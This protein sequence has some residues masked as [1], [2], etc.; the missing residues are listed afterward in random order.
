MILRDR[1]RRRRGTRA[2]RPRLTAR[3]PPVPGPDAVNPAARPDP[4]R[5]TRPAPAAGAGSIH[6][7]HCAPLWC[8]LVL[9][10][11]PTADGGPTKV[12]AGTVR[13]SVSFDAADY[14]EI[15]T[16]ADEKRVSVAWVV[17]EAVTRYLD[18]RTPL[19]ARER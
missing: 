6:L 15:K 17:R 16:I 14:G 2:V 3:S 7:C 4:R 9:L 1:G 12:I 11:A 8:I 10:M 13:V 18:D 5:A 19:F